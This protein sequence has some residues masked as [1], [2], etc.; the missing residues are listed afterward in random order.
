[1]KKARLAALMGTA[2]VLL[3]PIAAFAETGPV[4]AGNPPSAEPVVSAD[5]P[6]GLIGLAI[7]LALL[8][9]LAIAARRGWRPR[10]W[11]PVVAVLIVVGG[12]VGAFLVL[13]LGVLSSWTDPGSNIPTPF[14]IGAAVLFGTTVLLAAKLLLDWRRGARVR[15]EP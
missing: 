1:M 12:V 15:P 8:V 3:T 2:S 10:W 14:A 4:P 9:G 5:A 6:I 13:A 11:R 7:G